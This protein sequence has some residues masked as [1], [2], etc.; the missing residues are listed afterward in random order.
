MLETDVLNTFPF[1]IFVLFFLS[2]FLSD[3]FS[4]LLFQVLSSF[5]CIH[6]F[7]FILI[8]LF[9]CF[10][11]VRL[12]NSWNNLYKVDW[13]ENSVSLL[14]CANMP[15]SAILTARNPG[16]SKYPRFIQFTY[17][18]NSSIANVIIFA[19]LSLFFHLLIFFSFL[20]ISLRFLPIQLSVNFLCRKFL[21]FHLEERLSLL[22]HYFFLLPFF[23]FFGFD[24]CPIFFCLYEKLFSFVLLIIPRF[25]L[26]SIRLFYSFS[27]KHS[28]TKMHCLNI[29]R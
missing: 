10:C 8:Y 12:G 2:F 23:V 15:L 28:F 18:S 1:S 20:F 29:Q 17:F 4:L 5:L 26:Y 6:C 25:L 21:S 24:S 27:F 11:D 22:P 9:S 13:P 14:D 19:F 7:H 3:L 16:F